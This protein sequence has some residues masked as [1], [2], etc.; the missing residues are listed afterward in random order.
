MRTDDGKLIEF[1]EPQNHY[2]LV[3]NLHPPGRYSEFDGPKH[4]VIDHD[5]IGIEAIE[6]G[7]MLRSW[8]G[9]GFHTLY[10]TE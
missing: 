4:T 2:Y 3:L 1:L 6:A 9:K 8:S 5:S 7:E 10:L